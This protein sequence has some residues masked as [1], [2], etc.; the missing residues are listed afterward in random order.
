M[1]CAGLFTAS[2]YLPVR[3]VV[4]PPFAFYSAPSDVLSEDTSDNQSTTHNG[5]LQQAPSGS[6][7]NLQVGERSRT[8][9]SWSVGGGEKGAWAEW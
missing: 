3:C 1:A 8:T 7:S 4:R 5:Q 2:W 6:F 9:G